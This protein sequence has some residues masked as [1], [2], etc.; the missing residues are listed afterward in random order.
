MK[1]AT[2]FSITLFLSAAK[3]LGATESVSLF[4][5]YQSQNDFQSTVD[6][7]KEGIINQGMIVRGELHIQDML[8]RTGGDLGFDDVVYDRATSIEF[9]NANLTHQMVRLDPRNVGVCPFVISVYK[10]KGQMDPVNI[11]YRRYR[12]YGDAEELLE[13]IHAL[14]DEIAT[15]AI[16]EW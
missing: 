15:T 10:G 7:V 3:L 12:L 9:C 1:H 4:V 2:L 16:E 8:E 5:V 14:H 11:S 13:T 6:G